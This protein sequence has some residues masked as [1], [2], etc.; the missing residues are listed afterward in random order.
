MAGFFGLLE[1]V[2]LAIL[3]EVLD[4]Q[5]E[6]LSQLGD[7]VVHVLAGVGSVA[8]E[9]PAQ[10]LAQRVGFGWVGALRRLPGR[11]PLAQIG[12]GVLELGVGHRRRRAVLAGTGL[13]PGRRERAATATPAA[14]PATATEA[15]ATARTA[16][17]AAH[18]GRGEGGAGRREGSLVEGVE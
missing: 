1:D 13:G 2:E 8:I 18:G 14:T 17:T 12:P 7:G 10:A 9:Q 3:G 4:A 11:Q 6:L 15:A 5:V 16:A